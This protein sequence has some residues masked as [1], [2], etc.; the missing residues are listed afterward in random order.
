MLRTCGMLRTCMEI[1]LV[2]GMIRTSWRMPRP[3]VRQGAVAHVPRPVLRSFVSSS[4]IVQ[5]TS[6]GEFRYTLDNSSEGA[7]SEQRH[8]RRPI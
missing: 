5:A 6:V 1:S 7:G 2:C 8:K 4:M 3:V